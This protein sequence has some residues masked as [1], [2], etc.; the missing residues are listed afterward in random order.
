[1][2]DTVAVNLIPTDG[3][4]NGN[5]NFLG[6]WKNMFAYGGAQQAPMQLGP[7]GIRSMTTDVGGLGTI[8]PSS[9][10]QTNF[11]EGG[12]GYNGFRFTLDRSY[13]AHPTDGSEWLFFAV[14][15][16]SVSLLA[17]TGIALLFRRRR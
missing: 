5:L 14:P 4:G 12:I 1:V 15:E 17:G 11:V 2:G 3:P 16:P 9:V 10:V 6:N 8:V 13:D 7:L